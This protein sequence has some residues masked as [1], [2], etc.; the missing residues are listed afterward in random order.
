MAA[1]DMGQVA[2]ARQT[3]HLNIISSKV[4]SPVHG[5]CA[6]SFLLIQR[7]VPNYFISNGRSVAF[8]LQL[9]LL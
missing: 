6:L 3:F 1:T 9:Q 4:K 7:F 8:L 5:I 2:E